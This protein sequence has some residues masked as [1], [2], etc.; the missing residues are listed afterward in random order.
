VHLE[1]KTYFKIKRTNRLG[2]KI[3]NLRRSFASPVIYT[4]MTE[5]LQCSFEDELLIKQQI[6][7]RS[8]QHELSWCYIKTLEREKRL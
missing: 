3:R 1:E 5:W 6:F 2:D 8:E 4:K 7:S